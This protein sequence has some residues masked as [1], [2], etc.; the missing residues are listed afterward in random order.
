MKST[1][2]GNWSEI[3]QNTKQGA[4]TTEIVNW[5]KREEQIFTEIKSSLMSNKHKKQVAKNLDIGYCTEIK[6]CKKN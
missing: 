1:D 4:E 6:Q 2:S 3:Q 5:A